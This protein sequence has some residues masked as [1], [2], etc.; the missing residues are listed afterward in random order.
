MT[1]QQTVWFLA[2]SAWLAMLDG[3]ADRSGLLWGAIEA[4]EGRGHI[5][6]WEAQRAELPR[7]ARA[8]RGPGVRGRACPRAEPGARRSGVARLS[9]APVE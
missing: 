9:P 3:L 7:K 8:R 6:Q 4:D 5:G 2:Q 1:G